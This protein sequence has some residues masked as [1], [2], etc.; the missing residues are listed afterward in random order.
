MC[1]CFLTVT[2]KAATLFRISINKM[3]QLYIYTTMKHVAFGKE[4]RFEQWWWTMLFLYDSG[5]RNSDYFLHG[6]YIA[7]GRKAVLLRDQSAV[8]CF[9][10]ETDCHSLY[11]PESVLRAFLLKASD[12]LQ[13]LFMPRN[14]K[15]PLDNF[16]HLTTILIF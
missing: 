5:D 10:V 11:I 16:Q 1:R 13:R 2:R 4:S 8:S 3:P 15:N 14:N 12:K 9:L 6:N 7:S